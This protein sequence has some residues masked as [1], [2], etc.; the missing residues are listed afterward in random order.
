M[1]FILDIIE[2][3]L[4]A[5]GAYKLAT[6]KTAKKGFAKVGALA[7]DILSAKVVETTEAEA[8]TPKTETAESAFNALS[9]EQQAELLASF[10]TSDAD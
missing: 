9:P 5:Y 10:S 3:G 4:A 2:G 1:S 6:T 7:A 8:K